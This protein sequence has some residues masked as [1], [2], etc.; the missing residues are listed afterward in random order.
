MS[1]SLT[2]PIATGR[3]AE[4]YAWQDGQ[5]LKL[6]RD[7]CPRAWVDYELR[8]ARIVDAAGLAAPVPGDLV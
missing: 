2:T 4:V 6:D 1:I 8:I 3:T 7:W 5:V